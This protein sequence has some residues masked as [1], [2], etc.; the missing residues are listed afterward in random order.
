MHPRTP[1]N[2]VAVIDLC[3][4]FEIGLNYFFY[5]QSDHSRLLLMPGAT[6]LTFYFLD[7]ISAPTDVLY[8]N[9]CDVN[10]T[11]QVAGVYIE[12]RVKSGVMES[13]HNTF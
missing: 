12:S 11:A 6:Y 7:L 3:C 4:V 8:G 1:L 10:N 9:E 13:L 5:L 2:A